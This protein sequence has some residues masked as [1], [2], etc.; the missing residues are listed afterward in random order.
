M[1]NNGVHWASDYPIAIAF[2]D[3]FAHIV[4]ARGRTE[5]R[6]DARES[7]ASPARGMQL[8]HPELGVF[9]TPTG[10]GYGLKYRF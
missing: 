3:L 7:D 10:T 9:A 8:T 4:V 5:R 6:L 2:G 1:M